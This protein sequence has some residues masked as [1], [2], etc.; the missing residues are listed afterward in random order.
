M[1]SH[2]T[3]L[4]CG[5]QMNHSRCTMAISLHVPYQAIPSRQ[6][7]QFPQSSPCLLTRW[8]PTP[9]VKLCFLAR[10][11]LGQHMGAEFADECGAPGL[12]LAGRLLKSS[13]AGYCLGGLLG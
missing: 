4:V 11:I 10:C 3:S 9:N 6:P 13:F 2:T 12:N 7:L 8:T 1:V 5:R